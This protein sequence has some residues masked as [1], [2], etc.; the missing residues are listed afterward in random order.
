MIQPG[1]ALSNL[2]VIEYGNLVAGPY[3]ARLLG[4]AG[5]DVIKVESPLGDESRRRG[6]FPGDVPDPEWS[7]LYLYLNANKRGITL[8]L[9]NDRG[10]KVFRELLSH[11]DVLVVNHS[12]SFLDRLRLRR[13]QLQDI[14][15]GLIVVVITPFGLTGPYKDY[16]GDDLVSVSAGGLAYATPGLPD[17]VNDP[18]QEPPL[19][20]NTFIAEFL[21]GI[22]AAIASLAAVMSRSL[23]GQ[24]C[25]VD[26]SQQEAV[27]MVMPFEV[28]HASYLEPKNR[29]PSIFGVMPNAYMPC[30]DGYV[31]MVGFM[32]PHWKRIVS[33][34]GD[35]E[36]ADTE[37]FADPFE[38]ARNWDVL[39]PMILAWTMEHTGA[40]I[41]R[42]AQENGAPCFP[43][44]TV[45]QMVD[46]DHVK[47]R[48]YLRTYD[49][50]E[51]RRLSFPGYPVQMQ[52]TPWL[53]RRPAP[54]MSEHTREVLQEWLG[55]SI[56]EISSLKDMG[57]V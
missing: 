22:Q 4:D 7:G 11:A 29:Q 17:T 1:G 55:Y 24:G 30:R 49:G 15:P 10:L 26:V 6:P 56:D 51:G 53:L 52:A 40:E 38:R 18:D 13:H 31:V 48:G 19:R 9:E 37:V 45:G 33:M 44:Y 12:P 32:E 27:A 21:A 34:M 5:A 16:A 57:D 3:C 42:L 2:R 43:A 36:W 47:A 41:A 35:P 46:S 8:D 23:T 14:N 50:P 54:R 25:E 39:A 20:A 28:A